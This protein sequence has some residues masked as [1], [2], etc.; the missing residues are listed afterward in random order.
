MYVVIVEAYF[1]Q[2]DEKKDPV[3]HYEK[4]F[5]NNDMVAQHKDLVSQNNDFV[6]QNNDLSQNEKLFSK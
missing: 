3:S 6:S 1:L 2:C 4:L 5:L